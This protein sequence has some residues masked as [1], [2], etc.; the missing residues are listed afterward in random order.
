MQ[1][2]KLGLYLDDG[3]RADVAAGRHNFFNLLIETFEGIEASQAMIL[4]GT[5]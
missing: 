3:L 1:D 4:S 2:K 5:W